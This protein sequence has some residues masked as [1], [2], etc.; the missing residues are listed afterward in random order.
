M[1]LA[2]REASSDGNFL[3]QPL[4]EHL[5]ETGK[6]A[7][8]I[9]SEIGLK[10]LMELAGYIH[11]VGKSDRKFQ[12]YICGTK[13]QQVNHSSAGGRILEDMIS[14]DQEFNEVRS[15]KSFRYFQ[16]IL[17]YIIFA[18]H[19]IFD[20]INNSGM[21]HNTDL[22]FRYDEDGDYHYR[23]DV[24]PF[25]QH[26]DSELQKKGEASLTELIRDAYEEFKRVYADIVSL[27]AKNSDK[28]SRM[29]EKE[30]YIACLTRLCLSILKEADIYDSVNAFHHP[31]QHLWRSEER[32]KIWEEAS[33]RI[34][35]IYQKYASNSEASDINKA[36]NI[37]ADLAKS[38]AEISDS[39]IFKLELP[40]GAGK[41]KAGLRYALTNAR[42]YK[43]NRVF[44]ITAYLSVLEQ[45]AEDIKD[46]IKHDEVVLEHHS[47]MTEESEQE[48]EGEEDR[49]DYEYKT[50]LK[51]SWESPIILTTM[52]QFF[53]TLFKE[54]ASNIRR[55]CKLINSVVIIDEVQSLP[56]K[57][58]S[59]FNLMMNFMKTVMRCNIVHCT[60]TQP[61]LDNAAMKYRIYY[62]DS[63]DNKATIVNK[64]QN[65]LEC[66]RRVDFYNL[67]GRDARSV[68]STKQISSLIAAKLE[69]FD[70]CLVVLNTKSAVAKLCDYLED[71]LPETE[72][73]YLTTNMCAANRLD[74]ISDMKV[75]LRQ[76]R[77][78]CAHKKVVCVSTQ[79]IEA[80]VDVDFDVV[81]RSLAGIDSLI[82]CAGRCNREGKL[83]LD[84]KYVHGKLYIIRYVEENLLK[85]PD[86]KVTAD[87]S[88]YAIRTRKGAEGAKD[89]AIEIGTLQ[90]PYFNKYYVENK[91]KLHYTDLKRNSSM[92]EELGRNTPDR[93]AY[94]LM[95]K[96]GNQN[97]V[98]FQAF[99]RAAENFELIGQEMTGVIVAYKNQDLLDKL[100][101]AMEKANYV[102][103]KKLLQQ[104][105]RYTINLYT[106]PK[107]QPYITENKD[108]N[109]YILQKE[110]YNGKRGVVM[111]RLADL[112]V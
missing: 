9:G 17:T 27:A 34:E 109:I 21:E 1:L 54:R 96:P 59:N 36:R 103:V 33:Q 37:L 48:A 88:E 111:D 22:R 99:R 94:H 76:N 30:Y 68:I 6:R 46:V 92:L 74:I 112:I 23:E 8:E 85:L 43:R 83:M 32:I 53:N 104:L 65:S 13:K 108:F 24:I 25:V 63:G 91:N 60:A 51:D 70:S 41:T 10:A 56:L 82:Q 38:A 84:G 97:P 26:F 87:A 95:G 14:Y 61:V 80:G 20:Q 64:E 72:I 4:D 73:I 12:G 67:T 44:Y 89:D 7:G 40:T 57:V 45:N 58:L 71:N 102:E 93:D 18:H 77:E 31:K 47:N 3:E 79:L 29:E 107:N 11:D 16:E 100:E 110:Y 75:K 69:V 49:D 105:Q 86:I 78:E 66:F 101:Q 42:E 19:G 15:S 5:Y 52:V 28:E 106:S 55:F 35:T 62:G 90:E 2:H 98:L 39:G 50:Y 81:F